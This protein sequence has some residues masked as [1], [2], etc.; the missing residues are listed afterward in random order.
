MPRSLALLFAVLLGSHVVAADPTYWQDVRP[1][2]RKNCTVCHNARNLTEEDL[3]G[4]LSL[5]GYANVLRWKEKNRNLVKAKTSADS[6]LH[7]VL[8]ATSADRRMPPGGKSLTKEEIAVVR[9]WIDGGAK[10]GDRPAEAVVTNPKPPRRKL[11]VTLRAAQLTLTLK[12]GPLAPVVAVAY[13]PD[14][15][16]L[17]VGSYGKVTVWDL[18]KAQPAAT[19]T[20]V[21]GAV[22]DLRFSPDG[23]LLAVGGGK[24]SAKGDLRL[25]TVSDWKLKAVLPGHEDVVAGVSFRHDSKKLASASYDRTVRVWDVESGKVER[26]LT[27][28][29]DF[30]HAVAFTPDGKHLVSGSK[31][32]SARLAESNTGKGKLTFGDR[33]DDVLGVAVHPDGKSVVVSGRE[34]ALMWWNPETGVKIRNVGG[35]RGAV[36]EIAFTP[37]GKSLVSGGDDGTAR[38]WDGTTGALKQTMLA[39]SIVYAVAISPD[40]KT[41]AA[42]CFDGLTRLFDAATGSPRGTLLSIHADHLALSPSGHVA[43]SDGLIPRGRWTSA[44]K[45]IPADVAWKTLRQPALVLKSLAGQAVP[46]PVFPAK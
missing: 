11:D 26:T 28:H 42:G 37:D 46:A 2:L 40:G 19:L 9:A 31:D 12:V 25:F 21:L 5:D 15:K 22:N 1:I 13:H 17:A 32:R 35:H 29:S 14:G 4:G 3:S 6:L 24:P 33:E 34:P 23:K 39:G 7:K 36:H 45:P 20:A 41:V 27:S 16:L 43:A 44:N 38:V 18:H 10:E 30:V 8:V